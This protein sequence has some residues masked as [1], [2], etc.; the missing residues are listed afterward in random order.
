MP[1]EKSNI[2]KGLPAAPGITIAPA[3][4][5]KKEKESINSDTIENVEEAIT[6]L[7][8]SLESSRKELKKVFGLAI[9]KLGEKRAAIF[10]AQI[11]I[12]D[13]PV[14]IDTI[15]KR[16]RDE[17]RTSEYIVYDE[18]SKYQRMMDQVNEPYMKERS[19]DIDDIKNRIIRNIK[20]KKWK[21]KITN[22][23]IVVT[24]NITP[25]DTVLFSRA[26]VKGY[27]TNFGGLTSHAAIVARSLHIPA[28]LGLHDAT[29]KIN[30]GDTII[31][32]GYRGEVVVAPTDEQLSYYKKRIKNLNLYDAELSKL[33][34]LPAETTD[35]RK[36]SLLANLD[37]TEEIDL[38][39]QNGA[40]GI[41]LV[42][43]EQIFEEMD[44]FPTEEVQLEWY[45]QISE[46]IYPDIAIIRV[47]DIGGDKILPVDVKEA[48]PFLGWR[49]IRFL[50]D[51]RELF[52][53]QLR[54]ILRASIH[55]NIKV[56]L[57]MIASL[58]EVR[59]TKKIMEGCKAELKKEGHKFDNDIEL[60]IM[61]EVPSAAVLAHEF[62]KEVSF[63]SIGT[64]DLI[65]YLLAVDRG[66]EIV[67]SLYQEFHP[68]VVRTIDFII[69]EGK[70][71]DVFVSICGE[72]A[73]DQIAIPLLIGLGLDS[74][75]VSPALIPVTKQII[76]NIS[77]EETQ[78]LVE[79]CLTAVTEKDI[80]DIL[81]NYFDEKVKHHLKSFFVTN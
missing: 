37:L 28:V 65:Q 77:F 22:D 24:D 5:F 76:R 15:K 62:A 1:K 16:I 4:L 36:I 74:L 73:S 26:N 63:F 23:V 33:K 35:G 20:K 25:A 27:V 2:Y 8:E 72:M 7:E 41:G 9:D 40:N 46:N 19:Q 45:K 49:G 70:Q 79:K 68:S 10:E 39:V 12:L 38:I 59:E 52:K 17:K 50:L 48:N 34:D 55:K 53:T 42:R 47:L 60:G 29:A 75:S 32:D 30:D 71:N 80:K 78:K 51:N 81:T 14:L 67:S 69:K 31:V 64:N 61:I 11:M 18:I 66:N 3:Y 21:S 58:V 13:D 56:M 54:A 44:Q 57:P 43:T 6:I